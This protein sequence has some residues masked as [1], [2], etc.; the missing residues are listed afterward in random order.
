[1]VLAHEVYSM[2]IAG[3]GVRSLSCWLVQHTLVLLYLLYILHSN[4]NI[5]E[6]IANI[7]DNNAILY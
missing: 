2:T 7:I 6:Y 4:N 5:N 3:T 1:M